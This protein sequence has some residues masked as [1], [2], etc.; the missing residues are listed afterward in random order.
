MPKDERV[1]TLFV[2][3]PDDVQEEAQRVYEVVEELNLGLGQLH[4]VRLNV[5][6]WKTHALPGIG[7]DPQ[8]VIN[9][10]L[11]QD[12][13]IFLGVMWARFGTVTPRAGSG[14]EEEF[15][16]AVTRYRENPGDVRIMF[17]F[18]HAPI[19]MDN[20]DHVQLGQVMTFRERLRADGI[21][22]WEFESGKEFEQ[23]LRRHLTR[24]LMEL[25]SP[26][27]DGPPDIEGKD[28]TDGDAGE[29]GTVVGAI[30]EDDEEL[31][32]IDYLDQAEEKFDKLKAI[33]ERMTTAISDVGSKMR[34]RTKDIEEF[35]G[36]SKDVSRKDARVLFG[37]AATDMN[38]FAS[39]LNVDLPG[40]RT[41]LSAG[42]RAAREAA[43]LIP[44]GPTREA[45]LKKSFDDLS[46]FR[47]NLDSA[48]DAISG[49]RTSV[50]NLP[51]LTAEMNRAKKGVSVA[52]TEV[53][54][55]M[56]G[57]R[58]LVEETI[59]GIENRSI[60]NEDG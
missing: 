25:A 41:T 3:C 58:H 9:Q 17:Y 57:G 53:L 21:L 39:Q 6:G 8:Q 7:S 14:T 60:I 16:K 18:K 28:V 51:K 44:D 26:S 5:V 27:E 34:E 55:A 37:R 23:N 15:M 13:D 4:G 10:Q 12:Y 43:W 45:Q 36:G 47:N 50:Q 46:G 59:G 33:V 32:Y 11:P 22:Y 2:A 42:V 35:V 29:A 38:C 19:P 56:T 54:D 20:I 1:V 31:G 30:G 48:I 40:F 24:Q 49:F 52:L